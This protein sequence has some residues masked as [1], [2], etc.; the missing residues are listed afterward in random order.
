[1]HALVRNLVPM[2]AC[3]LVKAH[4]LEQNMVVC[5]SNVLHRTVGAWA[6]E[7]VSEEHC[8][9]LKAVC[10]VVV[11]A[12]KVLCDS[13][14]RP[15]ATSLCSSLLLFC[16]RRPCHARSLASYLLRSQLHLWTCE[17]LVCLL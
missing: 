3:P 7:G 9:A 11:D 14:V 12:L 8:V 2:L 15:P 13:K 5:L 17:G 1:V 4:A 6:T 10:Q 16:M